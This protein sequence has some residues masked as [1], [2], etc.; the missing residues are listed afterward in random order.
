M[1]P[2]LNAF[3]IS[4]IRPLF[5]EWNDGTEPNPFIENVWAEASTARLYMILSN[6]QRLT[7]KV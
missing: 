7:G 3:L 6:F 2:T 5:I 4:L 1:Q